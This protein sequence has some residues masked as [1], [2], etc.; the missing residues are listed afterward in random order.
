MAAAAAAER[1]RNAGPSGNSRTS[2][3]ERFHNICVAISTGRLAGKIGEGPLADA[4]LDRIIYDSYTILI[5]GEESMR[6]KKSLS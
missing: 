3:Q 1:R 4:I 6:K 2:S 5:D